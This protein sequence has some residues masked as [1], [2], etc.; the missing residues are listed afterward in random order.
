M[1][2][3]IVILN[4]ASNDIRLALKEIDKIVKGNKDGI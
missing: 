4:K 1:N 3:K 2:N